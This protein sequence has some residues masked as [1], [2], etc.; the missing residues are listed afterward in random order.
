MVTSDFSKLVFP[1]LFSIYHFWTFINV[2][3]QKSKNTFGKNS[4]VR[5]KI[6]PLCSYKMFL[7]EH[8][9]IFVTKPLHLS[10]NSVTFYS[11]PPFGT[12]TTIW[13]DFVPNGGFCFI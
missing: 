9:I 10:N 2:Q 13:N 1:R 6:F 11:L 3:K 12:K 8:D 5:T 7:E 4:R